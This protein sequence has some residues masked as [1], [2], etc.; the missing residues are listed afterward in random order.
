MHELLLVHPVPL[1]M[2]APCFMEM[3]WVKLTSDWTSD[4]TLVTL[5]NNA[6]TLGRCSVLS[7]FA[8]EDKFGNCHLELFSIYNFCFRCLVLKFM[9]VDYGECC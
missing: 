7:V 3:T 5:L 1:E 8:G 9:L 6:L 4:H 2:S